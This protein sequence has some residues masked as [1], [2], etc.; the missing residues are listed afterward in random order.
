MCCCLKVKDQ[1]DLTWDDMSPMQKKHRIKTLWKKAK[2][3]FLFQRLKLDGQN[4][5]KGS[6]YNHDEEGDDILENI[7]SSS[8]HEWK[9]WIIRQ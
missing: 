2:R 4:P 8:E 5:K 7:N 9:W 1:L 6:T 3:V